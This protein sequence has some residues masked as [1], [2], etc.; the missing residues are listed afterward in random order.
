MVKR[1]SN[2]FFVHLEFLP[3]YSSL[4]FTGKLGEGLKVTPDDKKKT[5]ARGFVARLAT[6]NKEDEEIITRV[7]RRFHQWEKRRQVQIRL[8]LESD[9]KAKGAGK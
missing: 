4:L 2:D 7:K 5:L 6:P 1:I 9:G 8:D 3:D